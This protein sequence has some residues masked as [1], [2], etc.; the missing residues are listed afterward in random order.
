MY[1]RQVALFGP[2]P[3]RN[4]GEA[5]YAAGATAFLTATLLSL[6]YPVAALRKNREFLDAMRRLSY[7]ASLGSALFCQT[8]NYAFLRDSRMALERAEELL[9]IA[10]E[11]GMRRF[12]ALRLFSRL[13]P[14]R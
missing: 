12:A 9:L 5:R 1:K 13:G 2:G 4:F 7:P 3:F 11:H 10:T 8:V 6:G 14:G